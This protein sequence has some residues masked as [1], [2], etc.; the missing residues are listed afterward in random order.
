MK[1][2]SNGWNS[3]WF[4]F[5]KRTY[6]IQSQLS[7][8]ITAEHFSHN[9][10]RPASKEYTGLTPT[11]TPICFTC[12]ANVTSSILDKEL[13]D[14]NRSITPRVFCSTWFS[15]FSRISLTTSAW[16]WRWSTCTLVNAWPT[17]LVSSFFMTVLENL[18]SGCWWHDLSWSSSRNFLWPNLELCAKKRSETCRIWWKERWKF[19]K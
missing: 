14:R 2:E 8:W 6:L 7:D 9:F 5:F 16:S 1:V 3:L 18:S 11:F 17:F 15:T 10:Q 12:S 13:K 4:L 19:E